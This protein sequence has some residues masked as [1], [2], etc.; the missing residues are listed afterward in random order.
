MQQLTIPSTIPI[1]SS[2]V[3]YTE[4]AD[5]LILQKIRETPNNI[6]YACDMAARQLGRN[7]DAISAR[8]YGYLR[9]NPENK[10][11]VLSSP[12][13]HVNNTKNTPRPKDYD[14]SATFEGILEN[15][16]TLSDRQKRIIISLLNR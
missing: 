10:T 13:G 12:E 14:S 8:Y 2:R 1:R 7:G 16:H 5:A 4:A 3:R 11:Y 6:K 15:I 9:K